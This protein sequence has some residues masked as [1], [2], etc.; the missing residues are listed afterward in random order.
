M[1]DFDIRDALTA[2]LNDPQAIPTPD[3]AAELVDCENDPDSFTPPLVN[4]VLH[5]VTDAIADAP[6]AI[7]HTRHLDTVQFLLQCVRFRLPFPFCPSTRIS[8]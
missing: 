6:D 7:L 3:A 2:Y 1:T 8:C 4:G 5:G